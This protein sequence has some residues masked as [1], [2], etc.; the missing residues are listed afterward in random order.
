MA[1]DMYL[2]YEEYLALAAPLMPLRGLRW[3]VP[4]ESALIA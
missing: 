1:H 4:V 3:N 2:T